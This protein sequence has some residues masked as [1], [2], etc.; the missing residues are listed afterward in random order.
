MSLNIA[1]SMFAAVALGILA[2]VFM[3]EAVWDGLIALKK[4]AEGLMGLIFKDLENRWFRKGREEG[5]ALGREEGRE[6]GMERGL[7]R[8][9]ERGMERGLEQGREAEYNRI[10]DALREQGIDY[11]PPR[12]R[13]NGKDTE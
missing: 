7:E 13:K 10:I 4:K 11:T 5:I 9:L 3:V 12:H 1:D 8:G 6:Q 2:L